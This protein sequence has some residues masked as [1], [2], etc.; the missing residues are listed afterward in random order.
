M[1]KSTINQSTDVVTTYKSTRKM[2]C[3]EKRGVFLG[4]GCLKF[5]RGELGWGQKKEK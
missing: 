5:G 3:V 4:G 1:I 2:T